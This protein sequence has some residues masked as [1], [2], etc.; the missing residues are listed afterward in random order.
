METKLN[1]LRTMLAGLAPEGICAAFSGGTDS[2]LLLTVLSELR[3][4]A[5]YPL[6]AV[7]FTTAFQTAEETLSAQSLAEELGVPVETVSFDVLSD[8]VLRRNPPDRC[9]HCKRRLFAEMKRIAGTRGLTHLVDGTNSDDTKVYRPGRKALEEL[10][11][12]SPLAICG[13]TKDEV[14]AAARELLVP[15]ADKPSSP[16]LATRFPYGTELTDDA[17]RRVECGEAYLRNLG[18]GTVRLRVHGPCARLET[19]EE[20]FRT[21]SER[22]ARIAEEL[23]RIGFAYAALDLEGFRS[24]SMDEP[25]PGADRKKPAGA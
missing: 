18:L 6:L 25:L 23:R 1:Q 3:A 15:T 20:G 19:D 21:V 11:V 24:G 14:R 22:R 17:L 9:Y 5:P 4:Q 13:F 8:P 2:S 12:L 16:C 7:I 10:G